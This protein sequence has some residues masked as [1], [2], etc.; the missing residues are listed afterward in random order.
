[1]QPGEGM[2]VTLHKLKLRKARERDRP[3]GISMQPG[4]WIASYFLRKP[5]SDK[6][7]H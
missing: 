6:L 4:R 5:F 7:I 1:M 2:G 3:V